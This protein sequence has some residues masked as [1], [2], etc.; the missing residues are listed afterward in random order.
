MGLQP[1]DLPT[2]IYRVLKALWKHP[3]HPT[4]IS[5]TPIPTPSLRSHCL[6]HQRSRFPHRRYHRTAPIRLPCVGIVQQLGGDPLT[7]NGVADHVHLLIR[8]NKSVSDQDFMRDLKGRLFRNPLSTYRHG[9]LKRTQRLPPRP[10]SPPISSPKSAPATSATPQ[11]SGSSLSFSLAG[12]SGKRSTSP[13][14]PSSNART[15]R[16]AKRR[17]LGPRPS[18]VPAC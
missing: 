14:I 11:P 1:H 12:R 4:N 10:A 18:D 7:I 16:D 2:N 17:H 9:R 15:A 5:H 13:V 6:L 8:A 3:L